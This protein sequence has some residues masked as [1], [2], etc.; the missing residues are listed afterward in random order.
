M[1]QC[2]PPCLKAIHSHRRK[3]GDADGAVPWVSVPVRTGCRA[4]PS[5]CQIHGELD[6]T[7]FVV[8]RTTA[9]VSKLTDR[10]SQTRIQTHSITSPHSVVGLRKSEQRLATTHVVRLADKSGKTV[11]SDPESGQIVPSRMVWTG[12]FAAASS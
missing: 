11:E 2:V 8:E 5:C 6:D 10:Q 3:I 12:A 7:A 9:S 4:L 1:N